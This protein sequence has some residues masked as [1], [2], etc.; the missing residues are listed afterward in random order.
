[1]PT[2]QSAAHKVTLMGTCF[3]GAEIWTTG[4]WLGTGGGG[5]GSFGE[6]TQAEA[7]AIKTAWQTFFTAT[8]TGISSRYQT[9]DVKVSMVE[10]NG[11]S[12]PENTVYSTYATP[13]NGGG[14]STANPPQTA[15]VATLLSARPRGYASK[16]RMYLPGVAYQVD[17]T[18]H[19]LSTSVASIVAN[20]KT[21]FDALNAHADI[22]Y[23]VILNSP[24]SAG[25]PGHPALAENVVGIRIG[26]V[27][28][29]QRRRRNA[30]TEAYSSATVV[31]P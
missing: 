24:L 3:G 7:D 20:L 14:G 13:I 10:A 22:P 17:G 21:F 1:M 6:P 19:I 12:A 26:N 25:I 15:L 18:G 27:F 30:L 11:T 8:A 23:Q 5:G 2:Y 4:F 9:T 31:I 28:D 29:T 16:G